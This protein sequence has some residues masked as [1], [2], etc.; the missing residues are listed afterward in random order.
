[1]P[2]PLSS[3]RAEMI[4]AEPEEPGLDLGPPPSLRE[5]TAEQ[6]FRFADSHRLGGIAEFLAGDHRVVAGVDGHIT[7]ARGR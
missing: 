7:F 3:S 5:C 4:G 6:R 1:M 2:V